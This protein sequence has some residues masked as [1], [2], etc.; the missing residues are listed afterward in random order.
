M[1]VRAEDHDADA[2]IATSGRQPARVD[3]AR[4]PRFEEM[5]RRARHPRRHRRHFETA[6]ET[7]PETNTE[8]RSDDDS[9]P[10][11]SSSGSM[12]SSPSEGVRARRA[13]AR[14]RLDRA[15]EGGARR[16]RRAC[17]C[18]GD[19][20]L[21]FGRACARGG[22]RPRRHLEPLRGNGARHGG[23]D[24]TTPRVVARRRPEARVHHGDTRRG[25]M[26]ELDVRRSSP[27][28][29]YVVSGA[30]ISPS[31]SARAHRRGSCDRL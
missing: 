24:G 23:G 18:R 25:K 4:P 20:K 16:P 28:F 31:R 5:G 8:A 26:R 12:A 27:R 29:P 22:A 7:A 14:F 17:R 11:T 10:S 6:P 3:N 9:T 21:P 2:M 1:L 19:V 15:R 13:R 30:S